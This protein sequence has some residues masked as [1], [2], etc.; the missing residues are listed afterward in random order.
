MI[1]REGEGSSAAQPPAQP[2]AD[3][4]ALTRD[5]LLQEAALIAQIERHP[6]ARGKVIKAPGWGE[7]RATDNE[8]KFRVHLACAGVRGQARLMLASCASLN[9]ARVTKVAV[10][11]D[12]LSK[13]DAHAADHPNCLQHVRALSPPADSAGPSAS[14]SAPAATESKRLR[15]P[16]ALSHIMNMQRLRQ[17]FAVARNTASRLQEEMCEFERGVEEKLGPLRRACAEAERELKSLEEE[18]KEHEHKQRRLDPQP[19]QQQPMQLPDDAPE[20][21]PSETEQPWWSTW[22]MREFRRQ[23]SMYLT[24]SSQPLSDKVPIPPHDLRRRGQEGPMDHPRRGLV[25]ALRYWAECSTEYAAHLLAELT[26]RLELTD[27]V[28]DL[29][30][31]EEKARAAAT[32]TYIVDRLVDTVAV[33]KECSSEEQRREYHIVLAAV[34]PPFAQVGDGQGM[35]RRVTERLGVRRGNRS[36]AEGGRP[37][38]AARAQT[39][40]A[41]FDAL[42]EHLHA[43]LREGDAVLTRHGAA[44]LTRLLPDG[45]CVVT[46]RSG[47]TMLERSYA[48]CFGNGGGSARLRPL[49]LLLAPPPRSTRSDAVNDSLR[50]LILDYVAHFCPTSPHQRDVMRRLKAPFVFEEKPAFILSGTV[51]SLHAEFLEK[52]PEVSISLAQFKLEL[53]WNMKKAYRETCLCR[54]CLNFQWHCDA[55]KVVAALLEPLLEPAVADSEGDAAPVSDPQLSARIEKL[56]AFAKL[57]SKRKIGDELVCSACLG[58]QTEQACISGD[59]VRCGFGPM[60]YPVREMVLEPNSQ[61]EPE[62]VDGASLCW[63]RKLAWDTIKPAGGNTQAGSDEDALRFSVTGTVWEFLDALVGVMRNWVPHRFHLVQAKQATLE[64]HDNATPGVVTTSSDWSENGLLWL[65][66]MMQSEYWM[67]KYYSLLI[68]I[69]AFLRSKVWKDRSSVLP[70]K[71]E[72]TVQPE[73]APEGSIAFIKGSFFAIVTIGSN[74]AGEDVLYTVTRRDG[75]EVQVP[76]FRLRHRVWHRIAFLGLTNDRRHVGITTQAFHERELVFWRIW[77][78]EGRDAALAYAAVDQLKPT[79]ISCRGSKQQQPFAYLTVSCRRPPPLCLPRSSR[80]LRHRSLRRRRPVLS[81]APR[82]Q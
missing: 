27:R 48:A 34:M 65:R 50:R 24:R 38:A 4:D 82:D 61:G 23:E 36:Q 8:R 77:H 70:V 73:S 51:A 43:P 71:A 30:G 75:I 17:K 19:M 64:L 47:D 62:L 15:A 12:L 63:A 6:L 18:L 79:V 7:Q 58:D 14:D 53:P 60:W 32:D 10:L 42:L 16:D 20:S 49:P 54:Q 74:T 55:L 68:K 37:F 21:G 52:H 80:Q 13:L 22:S 33:L 57:D 5:E 1:P 9:L 45:G 66:L 28:R 76:R 2:P 44:E 29:L 46:F 26:H 3:A 59:C 35:M 25:G 81:Q 41:A 11:T 67:Q 72:V 69:A 56:V 78:T 40:R 31:D 39:L